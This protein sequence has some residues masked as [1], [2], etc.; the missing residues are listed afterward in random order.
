MRFKRLQSWYIPQV[1]VCESDFTAITDRFNLNRYAVLVFIG[2]EHA[3]SCRELA[4]FV[5][6]IEPPVWDLGADVFS[7]GVLRKISTM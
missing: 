6:K 2:N 1:K 5:T 3:N 7:I 4:T